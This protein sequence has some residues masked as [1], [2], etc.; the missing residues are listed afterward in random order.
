MHECMHTYVHLCVSVAYK[1]LDFQMDS[2]Y[3]MKQKEWLSFIDCI[4]QVLDT[5]K[6]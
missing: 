2:K 5:T 6:S 4:I 1:I 3:S